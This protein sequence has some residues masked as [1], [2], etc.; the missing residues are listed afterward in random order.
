[1]KIELPCI[2]ENN[3]CENGGKCQ[4]DAKGSYTCLCLNGFSGKICD[5]CKKRDENTSLF[6]IRFKLSLKYN[7]FSIAMRSL[8]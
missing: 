7:I 6:L 1:M 8:S 5:I 4:D 3:P 2:L